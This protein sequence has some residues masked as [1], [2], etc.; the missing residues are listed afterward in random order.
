MKNELGLSGPHLIVMPLAMMH[1][2]TTHLS[3]FCPSLSFRKIAGLADER[4]A[5]MKD[6]E[7]VGGL[8][9][10]YLTTYE[11]LVAEESFFV[12]SWPWATVIL[13]E[14]LR[15]KSDKG[16]LQQCLARLGCPFRLLV[17]GTAPQVLRLLPLNNNACIHLV[18]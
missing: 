16:A 5:Q 7:A 14:G 6:A 1:T 13:D 11:A 8:Y 12:N 15:I 4:H 9:D 17:T 18:E 3:K 10:V 2:W